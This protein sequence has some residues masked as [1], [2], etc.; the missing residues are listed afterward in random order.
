MIRME[1]Q[2]G[3]TNG[4]CVRQVLDQE[5]TLADA[6]VLHCIVLYC[7]VLYCIV[8]YCTLLYFIVLYSIVL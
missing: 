6:I 1:R 5:L 7:I 3:F 8:L 4:R 2:D